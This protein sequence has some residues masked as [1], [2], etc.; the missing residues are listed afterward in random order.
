MKKINFAITGA[1][2]YIGSKLVA[3][4]KKK[5][6]TLNLF[7]SKIQNY[8]EKNIF[9]YKFKINDKKCWKKIILESD[10]IFHLAGN[11]SVY[12]AKKNNKKNYNVTVQPIKDIIHVCKKYKRKPLIIFTST[13]TVYGLKKKFPVNESTKTLPITTYDKHKFLAEKMLINASNK[14]IL[15]CVNVRLSNVYGPSNV[16]VSSNDRGIINKVCMN[17]LKGNDIYLFGGGEY[18]RD[19]IYIDD[20]V[21]ALIKI[22]LSKNLKRKKYNI[23]SGIGTTLFDT[24][25]LIILK[26]KKTVKSKSI[27]INKKWPMNIELIE[28]RNFIGDNTNLKNDLKWSP[29]I[30]LENGIVK[31]I[32]FLKKKYL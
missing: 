14:K 1:N 26:A 4:L 8:K 23:C 7:A 12:F 20:V 11:T 28:K 15:S 22:A 9:S 13:A 19:Y 5:R 21:D 18:F 29:K 32:N 30:N 17:A 16:S 3:K 6:I 10:V 2:G 31:T 27:I 25:K 24:F